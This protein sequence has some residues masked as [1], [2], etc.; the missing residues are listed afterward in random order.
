MQKVKK[1]FVMFLAIMIV[2]TM[3]VSFAEGTAGT[4]NAAGQST[5]ETKEDNSTVVHGYGFGNSNINA[6]SVGTNTGATSTATSI[7]GAMQWIGY[8]VAVGMLVYIGIKYIMASADE[9]ANLK[10]SL[11]RYVVGAVLIAGASTIAGWVF[12]IV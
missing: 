5:V 1:F 3:S 4:G 6:S 7:L 12:K 10:N 2:F 11:I 9:K 8:A